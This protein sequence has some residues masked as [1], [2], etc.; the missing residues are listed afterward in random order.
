MKTW[1]KGGFPLDKLECQYFDIC[2]FYDTKKCNYNSPCYA[3]LKLP[4]GG[5]T[6]RKLFRNICESFV[7]KNNLEFQIGMIIESDNGKTKK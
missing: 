5:I 7:E 1:I 3:V 2:K 6:A 4:Y